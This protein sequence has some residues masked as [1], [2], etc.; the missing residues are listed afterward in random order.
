M[1]GIESVPVRLFLSASELFNPEKALGSDIER[2]FHC[3]TFEAFGLYNRR[4]RRLND[5]RLSGASDLC[6]HCRTEVCGRTS[7]LLSLVNKVRAGML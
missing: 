1:T 5:I 2:S 7:C 4:Q 3:L 6:R